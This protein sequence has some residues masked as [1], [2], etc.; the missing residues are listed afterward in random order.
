MNSLKKTC[1]EVL[2]SLEK[3][4]SLKELNQFT[5]ELSYFRQRLCDE[6]F[7]IA[8]VG[9]FSSG[10]STFINAILGQD[11]LTHG[12]T[13]TTAVITRIVSV[14]EGD[15]LCNTGKVILKNNKE[16]KLDKLNDLIE[17]TATASDQYCVVDEVM[18][19]E[20]YLPILQSKHKII[21]VDTPGLN[22]VAEGH[23]EQTIRLI[24]QAHACIYLIPLR[25]LSESDMSFLDTLA[26][27]QKN[28]V[29][30]QNFIDEFRASEGDTLEE[31]LEIQKMLIENSSFFQI[32]DV[33][34]SICG[35]S[36]LLAL[37]SKDMN[38][39]SL[40]TDNDSIITSEDR[41]QYWKRSHFDD[42]MKILNET[43]KDQTLEILQYGDT[44]KALYS[45]IATL[46]DQIERR[47]KQAE[48]VYKESNEHGAIDKLNKLQSRIISKKESHKKYLND[49]IRSNLKDISNEECKEIE[50]SLKLLS[51]KIFASVNA[52]KKIEDLEIWTDHCSVTISNLVSYPI[53][54]HEKRYSLHIQSLYQMLLT[55]IE[56]YAGI[57]NKNINLTNLNVSQVQR[58]KETFASSTNV[59]KTFQDK[60][61]KSKRE[62]D[63]LERA[64]DNK[65]QNLKSTNAKIEQLERLKRTSLQEKESK[66]SR[67]GARPSV[68]RHEE[69][70]SVDEDRGG[71]GIL[72][73]IFGPK[74][75]WR[76][77][78]VTD[79]SKRRRWDNEKANIQNAYQKK[80]LEDEREINATRRRLAAIGDETAENREK[81]AKMKEKINKAESEMRASREEQEMKKR[82]AANEYLKTFKKKLN[83]EIKHYFF[84][85]DGV[86]ASLVE[87]LNQNI[88]RS[89]SEFSRLAVDW[90][91]K[92]LKEKLDWIE[93]CKEKE[94]PVIL[95]RVQGFKSAEEKLK[96][97]LKMLE[98]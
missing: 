21:L 18:S 90:Y 35:V 7:R 1:L 80:A 39:T 38:I 55:R 24:Q 4:G 92:A 51:E 93:A 75:V 52:F 48:E 44:K 70:Y 26:K 50:E 57:N 69:N 86:Y 25:G 17:Y 79:D 58:S 5:T 9:E 67:L 76:S 32:N 31:K 59:T 22:G 89:N 28:Y 6:E 94:N 13:E 34:Y 64:I 63:E 97:C 37:T 41:Q 78:I 87:Q 74:T 19:V 23:R 14:P 62:I 83:D 65:Q 42:F 8:V 46:I 95:K 68:E 29:F 53:M 3:I 36:A 47:M 84:S 77:R 2:N 88:Q 49:F 96:N 61:E 11:I 54:E 85:E 71:L 27:Y 33:S 66:I 56:E 20:L 43:F 82:L 72:D 60:I 45:W 40:Y 98:V 10:K 16:I 12:T 15:A 91:E 81:I 73:A 30:V